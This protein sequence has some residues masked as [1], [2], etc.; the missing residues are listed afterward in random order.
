MPPPNAPPPAPSSSRSPGKTV[1]ALVLGAVS[2]LY[3]LNPG[4]GVFELIP[5]N[6]PVVG[7]LDEAA[8]AVI[9]MNC[10]AYFGL[11]LRNLM[12]GRRKDP[13][14]EARNVTPPGGFGR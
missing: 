9:L 7:N 12:G 2:V 1:G 5:D 6:I 8:A 4:F 10:L 3:I 14:N 13:V 11:D